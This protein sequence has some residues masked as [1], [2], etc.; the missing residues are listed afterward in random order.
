V[1]K[2]C[3]RRREGESEGGRGKEGKREQKLT[4]EELGE[5]WGFIQGGRVAA[6]V[7]CNG[8]MRIMGC[9]HYYLVSQVCRM[10]TTHPSGMSFLSPSLFMFML[11]LGYI[12]PRSVH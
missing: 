4:A 7:L 8:A 11:S 12:S 6:S 2:E 10:V 9:G 3:C 1:S 5:A